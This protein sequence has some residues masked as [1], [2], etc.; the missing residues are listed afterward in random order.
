M[1]ARSPDQSTKSAHGFGRQDRR[2]FLKAAAAGGGIFCFGGLWHYQS[3]L[4]AR[5]EL[6]KNLVGE[7]NPLLTQKAHQ[8]LQSLPSRA[9]E[10]FRTWFHG[11]CLNASAFA[12]SVTSDDFLDR[13]AACSSEAEREAL[14]QVQFFQ[15]VV[16]PEEV[17]QR[18]YLIAEEAG[19]EL[20]Q[21]WNACCLELSNQWNTHLRDYGVSVPARL[22]DSVEPMIRFRVEETIG[23]IQSV[24]R[25]PALKST[26]QRVEKAALLLLPLT[27]L[28]QWM[29]PVFALVAV[30]ALYEHFRHRAQVEQT[31]AEIRRSVSG[32]M[33][34]LALRV[35]TELEQ[36]ILNSLRALRRWQEQAVQMTAK[37][38]AESAVGF[39]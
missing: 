13:M 9:R 21:S 8:E 12:Y 36:E 26:G 38:Y 6:E 28:G 4:A 33:A 3:T 18:V 25:Q 7:M 2:F 27:K 20:N 1:S 35:S 23:Q 19:D 5:K 17:L 14:F 39:F 22:I 31:I 34:S 16:T 37:G 29:I 30:H 15:D 10:E 32:Q 24:G 11:P